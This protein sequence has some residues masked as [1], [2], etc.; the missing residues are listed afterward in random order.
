MGRSTDVELRKLIELN[1]DLVLRT[2][3]TLS[4]DLLSLL[5]VSKLG[6]SRCYD[7]TVSV[8][9]PVTSW[10]HHLRASGWQS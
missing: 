9:V 10:S 3:F 8:P 2:P 7:P 5:K 4:L 1:L 6:L